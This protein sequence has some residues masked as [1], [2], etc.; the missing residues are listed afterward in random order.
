MSVSEWIRESAQNYRRFGPVN[1]TTYTAAEFATGIQRRIG[2]VLNYGKP[3]WG[4]D[5]D[6]LVILDACRLDLMRE[7]A[8]E[9]DFLP[10]HIDAHTSPASASR[11][12]LERHV[13]ANSAA[14]E[15]ERTALVSGNA[16][17]RERFVQ[18][19]D[20]ASLDEVW[21][22][23]WDDDHGTVLPRSV[24][25]A[26]IR[27]HREGGHDRLIAWYM[28]PHAPFIGAEWSNGF[29]RKEGFG[30]PDGH[31]DGKSVW[32]QL[33]DGEISES[34]LWAAY[35]DNLRAV[36]E[37]V[38]LL[39]ENVDG[40]V[41]VTSD[42]GNAIGEYGIYGHPLYNWAPVLKRVP[43]IELQGRGKETHKP[44]PQ[45]VGTSDMTVD[46]RLEALGYR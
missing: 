2:P 43:W 38:Q 8:A 42:H 35:K 26:A 29:D 13:Q 28:Q 16:F 7:V 33:R 11:E 23:S 30:N 3:Y 44:Q 4:E 39:V 25:D 6:V 1:A 12:F 19:A 10:A 41:V 45:S 9:F 27:Q 24:T 21:R 46:E 14:G 36:L 34:Q 37:E 18:D 17:T 15:I 22:H 32:Y 20:W 5:W 40:R 31:D